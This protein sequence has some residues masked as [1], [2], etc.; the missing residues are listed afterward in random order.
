MVC[1][2]LVDKHSLLLEL[3]RTGFGGSTIR[4]SQV[5]VLPIFA[6]SIDGPLTVEFGHTPSDDCPCQ[7]TTTMMAGLT[8]HLSS[9][10]QHVDHRDRHKRQLG[11]YSL[12]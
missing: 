10:E 4:I 6:R 9:V 12:R 3:G 11:S 1:D 8:S 2:S 7:P 5:V